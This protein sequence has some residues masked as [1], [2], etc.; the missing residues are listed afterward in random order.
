MNDIIKI[1]S[2]PTTK[3]GQ[4]QL[5]QHIIEQ[6]TNKNNVLEIKS[7]L[8]ALK[9]IIN[10]VLDNKDFENTCLD[11]AMEAC[12]FE[13]IK[14]QWATLQVADS[15]TKYDYISSC[16]PTYLTLLEEEEKIKEKKKAI[17]EYLKKIRYPEE[18]I[19]PV[20]GEITTIFPPK[21]TSKKILKVTL[22]K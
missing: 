16:H 19:S 21:K 8:V 22:N 15:A 18:Y 1:N 5:A 14:T 17:E 12:L 20:T 4:K 10:E 6:M 11:K 2:I 3:T 7:Q 9:N 13:P